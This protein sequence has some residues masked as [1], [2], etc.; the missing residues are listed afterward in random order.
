MAGGYLGALHSLVV[1]R[2]TSGSS[3]QA[4]GSLPMKSA[5][6]GEAWRPRKW[7]M[8]ATSQEAIQ[9]MTWRGGWWIWRSR[10]GPQMTS[11]QW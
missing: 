9:Q 8:C 3:W 4:M 1:Q 6:V 11:Q 10:R 5:A 2:M 7:W